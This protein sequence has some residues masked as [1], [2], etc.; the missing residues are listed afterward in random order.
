[1]IRKSVL[2]SDVKYLTLVP[3]VIVK[4]MPATNGLVVK[5]AMEH[6]CCTSYVGSDVLYTG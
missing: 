2:Y 5:T 3:F 4:T 6:R 1:M